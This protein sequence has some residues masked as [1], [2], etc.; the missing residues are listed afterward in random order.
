MVIQNSGRAQIEVVSPVA[1]V[2]PEAVM[3]ARR[4]DSLNG[5]RIALWWNSKARGDVAL[6]VVAEA[7]GQRFQ[8]V[9][10]V[11]FSQQYDHGRHFPE[12]YDEVKSSGADAV[13]GTTGD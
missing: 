3:P 5:K 1:E 9:E 7:V 2:R 8:S 10:F 6:D 12:R 11:R 4:V 13:V